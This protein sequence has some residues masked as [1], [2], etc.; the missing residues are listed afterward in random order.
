MES[1]SAQKN[2]TQTQH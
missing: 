1:G 2:N